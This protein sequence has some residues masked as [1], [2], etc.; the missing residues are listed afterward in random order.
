MFI[1]Q[2]GNAFLGSSPTNKTKKA[3]NL[4]S[5]AALKE[6]KSKMTKIIRYRWG[7]IYYIK[8]TT[9]LYIFS[10]SGAVHSPQ[11]CTIR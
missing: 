9:N 7:E 4:P 2:C 11:P 1:T 5:V 8:V 10:W 6:D 3:T